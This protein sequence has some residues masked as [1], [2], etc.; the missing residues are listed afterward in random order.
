MSE[1]TEK[2][3]AVVVPLSLREELFDL[4]KIS[5][6]HLSAHLGNYD[7]YFIAAKQLDSSQIL[8]DGFKIK[9]FSNEF[10]GSAQA[11]NRL[12]TNPLFYESF[13]EYKYILIYHLDS[14]VFSD[15]LLYW[16]NKD[17]DNIAPP[18]LISDSS[19]IGKSSVGNGGFSLRKV[20]SFRKLFSSKRYWLTPGEYA[21]KVSKR[22]KIPNFIIFPLALLA[23]W[24]KPL[25]NIRVHL[26]HFLAR[27]W[28]AEDCF[29][30]EFS[31]KYY[32]PFK[33]ASIEDATRFA[34]EQNPSQRFAENNN[35]LP[36]GCHAFDRYDPSFWEP[37]LIQPQ[38][39]ISKIE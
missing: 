27:K 4:E 3:V 35:K 37:Y 5:L 20:E 38:G 24:I 36:F 25:N 2:D 31:N 10:F 32:P 12:M 1:V 33:T 13:S 34:F 22:T 29:I 18:W 39:P 14:L 15:E 11:H 7:K 21:R 16:C 9:R 19:W 17:Y 6:H 30:S 23:S 8:L 28:G 26:K